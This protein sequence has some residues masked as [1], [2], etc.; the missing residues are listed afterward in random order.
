MSKVG[1]IGSG[2]FIAFE[3][4]DV[5]QYEPKQTPYG[6]LDLPLTH[7][8]MQ[9][10]EIVLV[11]RN[12]AK[13][14]LSPH[15]IN[16]RANLWA[17]Q[18]SK[19][20]Y[21][22]S[23]SPVSGIRADMVPGEITIPEQLLDYTFNRQHTFFE[24]DFAASYRVDFRAPYD[25]KLR[26][27]FISHAHQNGVSF[28]DDATYAVV[29]G[30]RQSTLAEINRIER[31]GGDMTGMTGMP[32]AILAKELSIPY[33]CIGLVTHK[34]SGRRFDVRSSDEIQGINVRKSLKAI[35]HLVESFILESSD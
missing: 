25:D 23:I 9:G 29:Q 10:Q 27:A 33:I 24:E 2:S 13:H 4:L 17:L 5:L 18:A 12:N 16:Y 19:V 3:H 6:N 32:E 1:I 15:L 31:D 7:A 28:I 34:A 21:I 20:D 11:E 8:L 35:H 22:L 30:P 14:P 26:K